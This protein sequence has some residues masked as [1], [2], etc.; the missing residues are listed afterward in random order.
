MIGTSLKYY[1]RSARGYISA[2]FFFS[3]PFTRHYRPCGGNPSPNNN[4]MKKGY[5]YLLASKKHGTLY[6]GVTSDFPRRLHEHQN[7]LIEGF[8]KRYG[9]KTLVWFEEHDTITA[10]IQREKS[11]KKYTRQFKINLIEQSNPDWNPLR[12]F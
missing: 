3:F 9:I 7:G 10:A 8:T 2:V 4:D 1:M 11:I 5:V 12:P 6:V